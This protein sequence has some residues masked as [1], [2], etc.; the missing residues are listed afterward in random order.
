MK[1]RNK[2]IAKI[3][4]IFIISSFCLSCYYQI[5]GKK[6]VSYQIT[7]DCYSEEIIK[8]SEEKDF[9]ITIQ[10]N[11]LQYINIKTSLKSLKKTNA[12]IRIWDIENNI[13]IADFQLE[14]LTVE[15]G[16]LQIPTGNLKVDKNR[17]Y[18]VC[19]ENRGRNIQVYLDSNREIVNQQIY[20]FA[21][22]K[23]FYV[24]TLVL[25][26]MFACVIVLIEKMQNKNNIFFVVSIVTGIVFVMMIPP[27]TAPDEMRHFARSYDISRGNIICNTYE[28]PLGETWPMCEFPEQM[29][30]ARQISEKNGT[31]YY[32]ESNNKI[33]F[34]KYIDLLEEKKDKKKVTIPIFG[35][36]TTSSVAFLPQVI[37]IWCG[38]ILHLPSIF[39]FYLAR[40]FN[41]LIASIIG[42]FAIRILPTYKD[43]FIVLFFAPGMVFLRSTC[44]TD[45]YL[46]SLILLF[47]SYILKIRSESEKLNAKN[48]FFISTLV[49]IISLIK[50]PYIVIGMLVCIVELKKDKFAS[51]RNC[52]VILFVAFGV[53]EVSHHFLD[54]NPLVM[55]NIY[56]SSTEISY[57]YLS[58]I[59]KNPM[60]FLNLVGENVFEKFSEYCIEAVS[61]PNASCLVIPYSALL[62]IASQNVGSAKFYFSKLEKKFLFML[63]FLVWSAIVVAFFFVGSSPDLG[64]IWGIQGRY[65]YPVFP[66]LV[67]ACSHGKGEGCN[68]K[69][70]WLILEVII[71]IQQ[72][73]IFE[74]YWI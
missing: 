16:M 9:D 50:L 11:N 64:Y 41:M 38:R 4:I 15:K 53:Y 19:F 42:Y 8:K 14:N 58:Y 47:I 21:Y 48:L 55:S 44:S 17:R 72:I 39:I 31:G 67:L 18:Q 22:K 62:I 66:V 68:E 61:L 52:M 6:L 54:N 28:A 2:L 12:D 45:G 46:F 13:E 24:L 33:A 56:A 63:A 23:I 36:H 59:I 65:F 51:L 71:M 37:G 40:M 27:Y 43:I 5:H 25:M 7:Q 29:Y 73:K 26:V 1:R 57:E 20:L 70:L 30:S 60:K 3:T 49:T 74:T 10:N 69:M 34:D 35:D 32:Y